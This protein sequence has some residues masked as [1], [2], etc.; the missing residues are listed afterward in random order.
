MRNPILWA[1]AAVL[2]I[3]PV[4]AAAQASGDITATANVLQ[5][6]SVARGQDLDFGSVFPGVSRT[7]LP[8]G[9]TAG[10]FDISGEGASEIDIDFTLPN[11]LDGPSSATMPVS[12][13]NNS[14]AWGTATSG[15]P[16]PFDPTTG[17]TQNLEA[18][19]MMVFIGGTVDPAVDQ[20]AGTYNGTVTMMVA[21][22]GN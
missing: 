11:V 16:F 5:P 18:G 7:V 10:R 19:A 2:L 3:L 12:F 21:Y 1:V 20:A 4:A 22:T 17:T 15:G 13:G 14:A 8:D 9:T 6:L